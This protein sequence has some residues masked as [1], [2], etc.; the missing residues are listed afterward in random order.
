MNRAARQLRHALALLLAT[1]TAAMAQPVARGFAVAPDVS[2]RLYVPSGTLR[3]EPWDRDSVHLAGT[4]GANASLFG[5]GARTHVKLGVEARTN[6]DATIP[7]A[8]VVV[9][10]P[11]RARVWIK[12]IDGT[13]TVRGLQQELEAYT[14]RGGIEVHDVAGTITIESIDAPVL[15]AG[16]SG[17]VRVRGSRGP[18][19]LE[20]VNATLSVSTVSGRVELVRSNAEGRIETVGGAVEVE[21]VRAGGLLELQSHGGAVRVLVDAARPPLLELSS[22]QG[23]VQAPPLKGAAQYGRIVARS[24]RG[25]VSVTVNRR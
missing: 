21:G 14:V 13:L 16:A 18:V 7:V 11:R 12:M 1:A 9:R 23:T 25:D 17:D 6:A 8:D 19:R 24:F 3:V 15:L 2:M 22:R 5:G 4:L 10:V 20:R